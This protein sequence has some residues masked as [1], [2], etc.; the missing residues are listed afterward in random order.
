MSS[1]VAF[2]DPADTT[3]IC[4]PAQAGATLY[5]VMRSTSPGFAAGCGE[6]L[7]GSS[8]WNDAAVPPVGQVFHY[9]VRAATPHVGSWGARASG[10]E[11]NSLCG[12]E[13]LCTD[14]VDNDGDGLADCADPDC[15][16]QSI[17]APAVFSFVDTRG[18]D[19]SDTALLDFF[20]STGAG[21]TDY[22]FYS[23]H[24]PGPGDFAVCA[25]RADFYQDNYLAL[26]VSGGSVPS[27]TWNRWYRNGT[28]PWAGPVTDPYDNLFGYN[29]A[30]I[31]GWCPEP[32]L[33]G[34][35]P[36]ILPSLTFECEV[37]DLVLQCGDGTW[38]LTL[39]VGKSRIAACGF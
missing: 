7:T 5:E 32:G 13:T 37:A 39:K 11:R 19:I 6:A 12:A 21:P 34:R 15:L 10:A 17:C 8:C 31:Y 38:S 33:G 14:G 26:A 23:V 20:S 9:L 36:A 18:D 22:I 25:A 29:C 27:G 3:Q 2:N 1:A 16:S 35:S 4:W 28:G 30:D 24:S